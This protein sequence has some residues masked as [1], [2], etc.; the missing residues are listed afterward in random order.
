MKQVRERISVCAAVHR[1]HKLKVF[2]FLWKTERAQLI[3]KGLT[4]A[5]HWRCMVMLGVYHFFGA[6]LPFKEIVP[7]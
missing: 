7:L 3:R 4:G 2:R 1:E 6:A 5:I